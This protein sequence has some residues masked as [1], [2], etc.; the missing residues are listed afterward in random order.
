MSLYV[1]ICMCVHV[2]TCVC[3]C[4]FERYCIYIYNIYYWFYIPPTCANNNNNNNNNNR[5]ASNKTAKYSELSKTHHFT[6]IAIET[7]GSWNDLAIEF[8]NE[9]GKGSQR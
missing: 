6:P 7:G 1:C 2:C 8:I 4:V 3:I 5:A 9:L